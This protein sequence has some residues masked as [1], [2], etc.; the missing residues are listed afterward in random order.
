MLKMITRNVGLFFMPMLSLGQGYVVA[1]DALLLEGY[2]KGIVHIKT[3]GTVGALEPPIDS[4]GSGFIVDK[5]QGLIATNEHVVASHCVA[6]YKITF[7]NGRILEAH[8]RHVDPL[9]DFAFLQVDPEVLKVMDVKELPFAKEAPKIGELLSVVSSS[10]GHAFSMHEARLTNLYDFQGFFSCQS[11]G[12]SSS[13]KGGSS[14]APFLNALGQVV[15]F[16]YAG[17]D[18]GHN[19]AVPIF[20]LQDA[21]ASVKNA[22]RPSRLWTG[23]NLS[24]TPLDDLHRFSDFPQEEIA[25]YGLRHPDA[26]TKALKVTSVLGGTPAAG[27]LELGDVLWSVNGQEVAADH[28][29]FDKIVNGSKGAVKLVLWRQG[30]LIESEIEPLDLYTVQPNKMMTFAG[31]TFF[32]ADLYASFFWGV[33]RETF[34]MAN[35]SPDSI[36]AALSG[37]SDAKAGISIVRLN[38]QALTSF[39]QLENQLILLRNKKNFN[40]EVRLPFCTSY[41]ERKFLNTRDTRGLSVEN[42]FPPAN[43]IVYVRDSFFRWSVRPHAH[44]AL[45]SAENL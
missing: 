3:H 36:F 6:S 45:S 23:V 34:M 5:Q 39:E 42:D 14:G 13:L 2:A 16:N 4:T 11:Y 41:N 27:R 24:P 33:E 1:S 18:S 40:V 22:E 43:P 20:Y 29:L 26:K 10:A 37:F 15:A 9:V 21:L 28:Y 30:Q 31:A 38:S 25:P 7:S 19:W 35:V 44:E 17:D 32:Q 8:L 12:L